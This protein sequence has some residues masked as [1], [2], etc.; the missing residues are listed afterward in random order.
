M[1]VATEIFENSL[2]SP[3]RTIVGDQLVLSPVV[4]AR[5]LGPAIFLAVPL[6]ITRT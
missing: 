1:N 2:L 3:M 5:A 6:L 4:K